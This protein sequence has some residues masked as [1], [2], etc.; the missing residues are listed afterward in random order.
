M[1]L[2]PKIPHAPGGGGGVRVEDE[3]TLLGTFTGFDFTG[4]GVTVTVGPNGFVTVNIPSGAGISAGAGLFEGPPGTVNVG[5]ADGTIIVNPDSIQVGTVPVAQVSG[6]TVTAGAGLTGGGTLPTT[7]DVGQNADNSILV[8]ANDIQVN[9]AFGLSPTGG[10]GFLTQATWF[11]NADTGNDANDGSTSLTALKT[12][13]ELA[14]R[15]AGR[16]FASSVSAVTVSLAGTFAV[17]DALVLG[18][19]TFTNPTGTTVTI[20]GTMTQVAAG[21]ITA[22][23]VAFNPAGGVRAALTDGAQNFTTHIRQRIRMTDGPAANAV[24]FI[25]SLGGGVTVANVGQFWADSK[26]GGGTA[27]PAMGNAYV[28]ETY[29]TRIQRYHLDFNG[30]VWV[31]IKD[32]EFVAVAIVTDISISEV[33][34]GDRLHTQLYGCL[35]SMVG[36]AQHIVNGTQALCGC[37]GVWDTNTGSGVVFRDGCVLEFA[38]C[39]FCLTQADNCEFVSQHNMHDGNGTLHVGRLMNNRSF[40]EDIHHRAFFGNINGT[41]TE[42]IR[43]EDDAVL[44][45]SVANARYWGAAGNTVTNALRVRNGCGFQYVTLP[46]MT[47]NVPGNDVVLANTAAIAWGALPAVAAPPNNAFANVRQ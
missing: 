24:T 35:F 25:G 31:K 23:F 7:V 12:L 37:A 3:G 27:T 42:H 40:E 30:P 9:P 4:G 39:W 5:A 11:V 14:R 32:I 29:A 41:I 38:C 13:A 21:T 43:I 18:N 45:G 33:K 34:V 22:A 6:A 47:G 28:I 17:T 44:I 1:S 20:T 2:W 46:T 10:L 36:F 26:F 16:T 19:T 8:N 15:W